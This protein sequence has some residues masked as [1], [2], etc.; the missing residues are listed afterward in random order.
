VREC[1]CVRISLTDVSTQTR[2]HAFSNTNGQGDET[3]SC[4]CLLSH[5]SWLLKGR[6]GRSS[7]DVLRGGGCPAMS[8]ATFYSEGARVLCELYSARTARARCSALA[9]RWADFWS[10]EAEVGKVA[11][12]SKLSAEIRSP[13]AQVHRRYSRVRQRLSSGDLPV[14][15]GVTHALLGLCFLGFFVVLGVV[16][17]ICW[18]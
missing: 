2:M 6:A 1:V 12:R 17:F 14:V 8:S 3:P 18:V 9:G 7:V 15:S 10:R 5:S 13:R 16:G 11:Q 4:R